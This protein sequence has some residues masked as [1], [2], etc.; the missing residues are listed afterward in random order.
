MRAMAHFVLTTKFG[1]HEMGQL[2]AGYLGEV[3]GRER[4]R[5]REKENVT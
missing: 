5:E 1:T 2:A 4:E 3:E